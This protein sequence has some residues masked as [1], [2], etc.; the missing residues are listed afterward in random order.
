MT[1]VDPDNLGTSC[2][3]HLVFVLREE[4]SRKAEDGFFP[5]HRAEARL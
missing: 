2:S 1:G 3:V 5:R 4:A